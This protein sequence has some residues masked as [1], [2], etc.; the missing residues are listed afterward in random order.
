MSRR[1]PGPDQPALP[2]HALPGSLQGSEPGGH[3]RARAGDP[4]TSAQAA[5]TVGDLRPRQ[6][7]VYDLLAKAG[8]MA[9]DR[10]VLRYAALQGRGQVPPQTPSSIRTRRSELHDAGWVRCVGKGRNAAGNPVKVWAANPW[11]QPARTAAAD[12]LA[13]ARTR[14][15]L[16]EQRLA[17]ARSLLARVAALD[18]F[19]PDVLAADVAAWLDADRAHRG[20]AA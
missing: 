12:G 1:N 14:R 7:A 5:A 13:E 8:P 17:T 18:D 20:G 4:D 19:I 10:L 9:D 16:A 15:Q 11:R 3:A 2:A 6:R